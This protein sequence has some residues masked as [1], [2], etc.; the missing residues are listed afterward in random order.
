LLGVGALPTAIAGG[1]AT[2]LAD[3]LPQVGEN[4]ERQR[5][6]GQP[7]NLQSAALTGIPQAAL[8][9]LNLRLGMLPKGIQNIFKADAAALEKQV[10][11]GALKPEEAISK[12]SGN[13]KN[14]LLSTGSAAA[15][16]AG[17]MGAEEVLRR[18]QAGQSLTD[19]EA[20]G[21]Y[22]DIG[23]GALAL[24]PL[25]GVPRGAC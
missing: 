24:A 8:S 6:V 11:A 3:Y 4:I 13:L 7:E 17:T 23:K 9:G 25:F 14:I 12:L 20:L 15:V 19:E 1:V 22:A 5:D 21:E 16:G 10:L 2:A 18:Q